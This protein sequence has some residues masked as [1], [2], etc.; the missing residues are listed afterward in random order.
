VNT[1]KSYHCDC[2]PGFELHNRNECRDVDECATVGICSQTCINRL[3]SYKCDCVDGYQKDPATGRCKA[4]AGRP[5]L[6][7]A[8][9]T[10]MRKLDLD[11]LNMEPILN[12]TTRS[13]CALDYDFKRSTLFWSDVM[14]EKIYSISLAGGQR[15]VVVEEGVVTADGLAVDWV[16]FHLYWTDTGTNTI[17]V[18]DYQVKLD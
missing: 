1:P 10:D 15:S 4:G 2:R 17:S 13:S 5:S 12:T 3:G 8:H 11:R 7:F 9:K 16:H 18:S 6:I 14:E